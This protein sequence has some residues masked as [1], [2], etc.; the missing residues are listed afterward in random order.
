[1]KEYHFLKNKSYHPASFLFLNAVSSKKLDLNPIHR[2]QL[3]TFRVGSPILKLS[4]IPR[5]L[6]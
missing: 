3:S 2:M 5:G 1:M 4:G 6:S